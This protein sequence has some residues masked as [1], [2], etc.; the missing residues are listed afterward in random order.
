MSDRV[1][2]EIDELLARLGFDVAE[3]EKPLAVAPPPHRRSRRRAFP[4]S[5]VRLMLA[6]LGVIVAAFLLPLPLARLL[7]L[8]GGT[9]LLVAYLTWLFEPDPVPEGTTPDWFARLYRWLYGE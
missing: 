8:L 3:E 5:P 4:G 6:C 1:E 9:M 7:W 2:R